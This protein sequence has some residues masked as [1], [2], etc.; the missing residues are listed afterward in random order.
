MFANWN[1]YSVM[2]SR[3]KKHYDSDYIFLKFQIQWL[4]AVFNDNI[5]KIV[6]CVSP[7]S[8]D[9]KRWQT[10][11]ELSWS[12]GQVGAKTWTG[13]ES[14]PEG[15]RAAVWQEVGST[16]AEPPSYWRIWSEPGHTPSLRSSSAN[17]PNSNQPVKQSQEAA[18]G[19][20]SLVKP[21][22]R[23][24]VE[25]VDLRVAAGSI[26]ILLL[27]SGSTCLCP[28]TCLRQ[29]RPAL[30]SGPAAPQA[31]APHVRSVV[32]RRDS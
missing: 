24:S 15:Q 7:K 11:T 4:W 12:K 19:D 29:D 28:H 3:W 16:R 9:N 1:L 21:P 32:G 22:T 27:C 23:S 2:D 13:G 17:G 6:F 20:W 8:R 30:S 5:A 26:R 18:L 14:P 25:K 10:K 31:L